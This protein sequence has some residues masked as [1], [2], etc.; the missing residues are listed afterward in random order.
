[1]KTGESNFSNYTMSLSKF[2]CEN[3]KAERFVQGWGEYN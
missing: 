3:E 1:M 2:S